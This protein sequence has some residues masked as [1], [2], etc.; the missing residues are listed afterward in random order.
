MKHPKLS[1]QS[2]RSG[3]GLVIVIIV[4]ALIGGGFWWLS[5]NKRAADKDA[6]A[7]G[8][9]MIQRITVNHD[10][11][12]FS[13]YLSPQARLDIPPMQ[14]QQLIS[15]FQELGQPTQPI[16]IDENVTWQS[17]F[18]EPRAFFTAHLNYAMGPATLQLT[19]DHPVSRWQIVSMTFTPPKMH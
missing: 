1:C 4:L 15:Q 7:F 16:Q 3:Q 5:S 8:R 14:Q 6:R 19:I 12:F 9:Q 18:F 2:N 11:A 13:T 10:L 17:N